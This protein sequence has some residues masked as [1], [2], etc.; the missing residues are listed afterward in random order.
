[1][2]SQSFW[3]VYATSDTVTT[4]DALSLSV[5]R[6]LAFWEAFPGS[7]GGD[8]VVGHVAVDQEQK[9]VCMHRASLTSAPRN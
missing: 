3:Q 4:L 6:V 9:M 7:L 2:L 8:G 1:M 5:T